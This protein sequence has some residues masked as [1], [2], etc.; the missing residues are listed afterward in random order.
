MK[1]SFN[2]IKT[3]LPAIITA[4]ALLGSTGTAYC[5]ESKAESTAESVVESQAESVV[6]S[7]DELT[8]YPA[9]DFELRDQYGTLHKLSDYRGKIILLNFWATWCP[10]CIDEMPDLETLYEAEQEKE[11]SDLVILGVAAPG[12]SNEKSEDEVIDFLDENDFL[13]PNLMDEN[14]DVLFKEHGISAYPTTCFIDR[15]GNLIGYV[16]GALPGEAWPDVIQQA[17]DMAEGK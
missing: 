14:G 10:Y 11:D 3:V 17:Y 7:A 6:E 13:Y 9:P 1:K 16:Q 15:E 4:A 2:R 12:F 8:V 5:A